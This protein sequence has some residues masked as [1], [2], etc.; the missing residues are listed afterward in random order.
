MDKILKIGFL[1]TNSFEYFM[2]KT[3]TELGLI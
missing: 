3:R 2:L 1:S